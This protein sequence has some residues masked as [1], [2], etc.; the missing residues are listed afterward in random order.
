MTGGSF[1]LKADRA[2]VVFADMTDLYGE[3]G[4]TF[5]VLLKP[6]NHI[7]KPVTSVVIEYDSPSARRSSQLCLAFGD[8]W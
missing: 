5:G 6:V 2:P 8:L 3:F 1:T 7:V 4:F